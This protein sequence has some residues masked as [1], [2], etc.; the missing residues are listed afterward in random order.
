MIATYLSLVLAAPP[1]VASDADLL[2]SARW[3]FTHRI[4]AVAGA[5]GG[6]RVAVSAANTV[7]IVDPRTGA[8]LEEH[9]SPCAP[10]D[11]LAWSPDG[12]VL[13]GGCN[14]TV[15]RGARVFAW[16]SGGEQPSFSG[17]TEAPITAVAVGPA[18]ATIV[19]GSTQGRV[20]TWDLQSGRRTARVEAH[21]GRVVGLA[22]GDR[23]VAAV[24]EAGVALVEGASGRRVAGPADAAA[25]SADGRLVLASAAG[26][27][28]ISAS[29][30]STRIAPPPGA[31]PARGVF[32]RRGAILVAWADRGVY[33]LAD[34]RLI[35][36]GLLP[37]AAGEGTTLAGIC[38]SRLAARATSWACMTWRPTSP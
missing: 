6:D 36:R 37:L 35:P 13:V 17:S 10:V 24:G 7:A 5:P 8:H 1:G 26:L 32:L 28:L 34:T 15:L 33:Q 12:A 19:A 3:H 30:V 21:V 2:G 29:G 25:W 22:A 23:G 4:N 27:E 14:S 16:R 9:H 18:G 11:A 38:S 20:I 31:G